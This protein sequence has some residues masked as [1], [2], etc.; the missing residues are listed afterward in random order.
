[1][2]AGPDVICIG[3]QKAG[4]RWLFDQ[5]QYHPDFWMPP[6]KEIHYLDRDRPILKS[7]QTLLERA[8]KGRK[9]PQVKFPHHRPW[10]E[11]DI[12]FLEEA[13]KLSGQPLNFEAYAA[14]FRFKGDLLSGD[15]TPGYSGLGPDVIKQIPTYFPNVRIVFLIREPVSRAWSQICMSNRNER[16]NTDLLEDTAKFAKYLKRNPLIHKVAFPAKIAEPWAEFAPS[17]RFQHFFFDDIVGQPA[18]VRRRILEFIGADPEKSS[19]DVPP[20]HNRKSQDTKM[21]LT[22]DIKAVLVEFFA[23]EIRACAKRFGGH[24]LAWASSYGI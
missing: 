16:F 18:D 17:V 1:M 10:D 9:D 5:L 8:R 24:A 11:R 7:V 22:D 19:G 21:T 13:A 23:D 15:I 6:T 20:D 3:M 4:T 2:S 12:E 14:L